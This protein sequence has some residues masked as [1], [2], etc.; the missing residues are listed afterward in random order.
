M[1]SSGFVWDYCSSSKA[2]LRQP[3]GFE[4]LVQCVELLNPRDLAVPQLKQGGELD[5]GPG[6]ALPADTPLP[7]R[8]EDAI[9]SL[10]VVEVL[11]V[12]LAG[13]PATLAGT[14]PSRPSR[15]RCR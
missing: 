14:R 15:G 6:A 13:A 7:S 8:N 10:D 2:L 5:F 12:I 3:G 11:D 4:G 1:R 9:A